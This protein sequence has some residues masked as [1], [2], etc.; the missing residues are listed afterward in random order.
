MRKV[1]TSV[2]C[3]GVTWP[4]PPMPNKAACPVSSLCIEHRMKDLWRAEGPLEEITQEPAL[5]LLQVKLLVSVD[6]LSDTK[7]W[8]INRGRSQQER[9][10]RRHRRD[11]V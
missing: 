7:G 9:F 6:V 10:S 5:E 2:A 11:T 8:I 4:W 3:A 1:L